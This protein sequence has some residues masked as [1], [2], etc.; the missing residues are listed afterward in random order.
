MKAFVIVHEKP[1]DTWFYKVAT[2]YTKLNF[3]YCMADRFDENADWHFYD[4]TNLNWDKFKNYEFTVTVKPGDIFPYSYFN[5]RI[6]HQI[7]KFRFT[8]VGPAKIYCP[9]GTGE[10]EIKLP[11]NF[12]YVNPTNSDTFSATH[13][14]AIDM[15]LRNSN[16]AYVVHNEI[17]EPVYGLENGVKWAMTVSSGFYINYILEDAG[18]DSSTIINH[19]DISK[20][21]LAVRKYTLEN[22]DGTEYLK[23]LDHIYEKF[24]L[25]D[26]FNAGQFKRGHKPTHH[27]LAHMEQ[28]WKTAGNWEKHWKEYQKCK[29]NYYV[30]NLGDSDAFK[31]I[32][33][34]HKSYDSSVFWYNGALKRQPANVNKTSEQSHQNA[35]RFM[36]TLVDYNPKMLVYG[37]DHCCNKFNGIS[38]QQALEQMKE[39][40]RATI[41]KQI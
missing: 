36:Q 4:T 24:P 22:W 17:P 9:S 2:N 38:S 28:K 8:K 11:Y 35:K 25:L 30:C 26:V 3:D 7:G 29:H 32:L 21:S 39:D 15:V 10:G 18:F 13:D 6:Q 1:L 19:I 14:Q 5:R 23:W 37:S 12:S 33:S 27:V 16:L 41:W 20:V 40:S 31:R 34:E